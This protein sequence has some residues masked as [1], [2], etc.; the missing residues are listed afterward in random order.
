MIFPWYF[1]DISVIFPWVENHPSGRSWWSVGPPGPCCWTTSH[2][3]SSPRLWPW[4][5]WPTTGAPTAMEHSSLEPFHVLFPL[6][7]FFDIFM[8]LGWCSNMGMSRIL[9][10]GNIDVFSCEILK[11]LLVPLKPT[12]WIPTFY[13]LNVTVSSWLKLTLTF[14]PLFGKI[15]LRCEKNPLFVVFGLFQHSPKYPKSCWHIFGTLNIR[16]LV[17]SNLKLS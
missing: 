12:A 5:V 17:V 9:S 1:R 8:G 7:W 16:C 6:L 10:A 3:F 14:Y 15:I 13:R 2:P 4:G 11:F